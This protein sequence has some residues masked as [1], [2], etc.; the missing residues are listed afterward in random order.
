LNNIVN[1][2]RVEK[3]VVDSNQ[4]VEVVGVTRAKAKQQRCPDIGKD[5]GGFVLIDQKGCQGVLDG[6]KLVCGDSN[7]RHGDGHVTWPYKT[8]SL[9]AV[10]QHTAAVYLRQ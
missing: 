5:A 2:A 9:G 4:R 8:I 6:G 3:V 10:N 7:S 1:I